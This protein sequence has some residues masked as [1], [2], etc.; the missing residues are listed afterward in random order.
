MRPPSTVQTWPV[1]NAARGDAEAVLTAAEELLPLSREQRFVQNEAGA[2]LL[3]GWALASSGEAE[4]G[5]R[6]MQA[7][8]ELWNPTGNRTWG[9]AG[10]GG[11]IGPAYDPMALVAK[12]PLARP[13]GMT[14]QGV[15]LERLGDRIERNFPGADA[16][17]IVNRVHGKTVDLIH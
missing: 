6:R 3:G 7:G 15:S 9:E 5:L 14:L 10:T 17:V 16:V 2:L 1:T 4:E 8:F 11:F 13:N 12:D